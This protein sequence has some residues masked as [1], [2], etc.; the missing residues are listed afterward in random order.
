MTS[1]AGA[2]TA[3]KLAV[4]LVD[5]HALV[6]HGLSEIINAEDD[7]SVFAEAATA[8]EALDAVRRARPDLAI[9]DLSLGDADGLEL[10]KALLA[11]HPDLPVLVC[12]MHDEAAYAERALRA[13]ARGYVMK[14][15]S[16]QT[17]LAAVRR[18]LSGDVHV[19]PRVASRMLLKLVGPQSAEAEAGV[20][21]LS[22]REFEVFRLIGR[23]AGPTEIARHLGVSVKTVETH[24]EHI[25]RKLGLPNGRELTRAAVLH[26]ESGGVAGAAESFPAAPAS[27]KPRSAV[28]RCPPP[29]AAPAGPASESG[30]SFS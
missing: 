9:V 5:D 14:Q 12:S 28:V 25:K 26:A 16:N 23:G 18:V 10:V 4:L 2:S 29:P 22:D 8:A 7:L 1:L 19:G 15:E 17:V 6:R 27:V 20:G 11:V 21:S 3:G 13:G 24:R 30:T